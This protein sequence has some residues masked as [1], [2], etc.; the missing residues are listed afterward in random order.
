MIPLTAATVQLSSASIG[1]LRPVSVFTVTFMTYSA[2]AYL[3][4]W[5]DLF[6]QPHD[7]GGCCNCKIQ[8]SKLVSFLFL[9]ARLRSAPFF[10]FLTSIRCFVVPCVPRLPTTTILIP[11]VVAPRLMVEAVRR[12]DEGRAKKT[13]D[14][15]QEADSYRGRTSRGVGVHDYTVFLSQPT[16]IRISEHSFTNN[17]DIRYIVCPLRGNV[18][19]REK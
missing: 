14:S 15:W 12:T 4:I 10:F 18:Q 5:C 2:S 8:I 9:T 3:L 13:A 17:P 16:L 19:K 11:P 7:M 6:L 1:N